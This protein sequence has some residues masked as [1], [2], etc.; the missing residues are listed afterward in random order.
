MPR[1]PGHLDNIDAADEERPFRLVTAPARNFLNT[2]FTETPT[3]RA[4]EG[5]PTHL[6]NTW[7]EIVAEWQPAMRL[8]SGKEAGA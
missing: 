6:A 5:R 1:L 3:S 7:R 4:R 2:S 8:H